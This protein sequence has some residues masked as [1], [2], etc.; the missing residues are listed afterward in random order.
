MAEVGDGEGRAEARL[1]G[2]LDGGALLGGERAPYRARGADA[3]AGGEGE[4]PA[5]LLRVV[6]QFY[7]VVMPGGWV[8]EDI[9]G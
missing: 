3:G 7:V 4:A 5:G 9:V 6:Y 2:G 8:V 1:D